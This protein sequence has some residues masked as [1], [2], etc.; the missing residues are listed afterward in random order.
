MIDDIKAPGNRKV[1]FLHPQAVIQDELVRALIADDYEAY[2]LRNSVSAKMVLRDYPDSILVVQVDSGLS[3]EQWLEYA[4]ELRATP[5]FSQLTLCVVSV[6]SMED[7]QQTYL[8]MPEGF[9]YGFSY[10]GYDFGTIYPLIKEMLI[11]EKANPP[12]ISIKGTTAE[13]QKVSVVFTRDRIRYEGR[14]KDIS[15]SGLTCRIDSMDPLYPSEIPIQAII[16]TYESTQLTV[17]GRVAGN[18]GDDDS[19]H[20]ILFDDN[21]RSDKKDDIFDLI[22]A[23]L[24]AEIEALIKEKSKKGRLITKMPR[25]SLYRK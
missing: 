18:H 10:S 11:Q 13:K 9:S 21:V 19:I 4:S 3:E 25:S 14:L 2:L 20:L 1:F 7:I 16:I 23:C 12:G 17:S 24:Q 22:Q 5:V 6:A 8:D 15:L